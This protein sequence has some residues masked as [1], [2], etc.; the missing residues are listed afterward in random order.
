MQTTGN[1]LISTAEHGTDD[2][3]DQLMQLT[4]AWEELKY[5]AK[6]RSKKLEESMTYQK[7]L[8]NLD[9][10]ETWLA[11]KQQL[12]SRQDLGDNMAIVQGRNSIAQE[13]NFNFMI[14]D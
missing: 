9:E 11:E 12:L 14:F 6:T 8:V 13:K 1:V 5:L 3:K 7:F 2:I 10:E 4:K